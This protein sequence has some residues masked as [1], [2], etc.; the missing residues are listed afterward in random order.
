M[1][2]QEVTFDQETIFRCA[3]SESVEL[4]ITDV[5]LQLRI[6]PPLVRRLNIELVGRDNNEFLELNIV[7]K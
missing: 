7:E 2:Q 3:L 6:P 5:P 1:V 4:D